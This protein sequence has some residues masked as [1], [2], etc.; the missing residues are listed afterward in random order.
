[1]HHEV[2][3]T[4]DDRDHPGRPARHGTRTEGLITVFDGGVLTDLDT[5]LLPVDELSAA[6]FVAIDNLEDYLPALQAHRA[7]AALDARH[8]GTVAELEDGHPR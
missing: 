7:R 3:V 8:A 1:M 4:L 5:V 2:A 6:E